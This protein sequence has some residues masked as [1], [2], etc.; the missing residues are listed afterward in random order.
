VTMDTGG[1]NPFQ[2]A[3]HRGGIMGDAMQDKAFTRRRIEAG[4]HLGTRQG[5]NCAGDQVLMVTSRH[6]DLFL[7]SC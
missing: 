2:I 4:S 1:G 5:V 6:I 3:A 7:Q